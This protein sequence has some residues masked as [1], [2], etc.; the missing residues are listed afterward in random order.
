ME[1][2]YKYVILYYFFK[3]FL[4]HISYVNNSLYTLFQILSNL[5]KEKEKEK[6]KEKSPQQLTQLKNLSRKSLLQ[7]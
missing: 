6:E 2:Q 3:N 5:Q 4:I 7:L 1:F